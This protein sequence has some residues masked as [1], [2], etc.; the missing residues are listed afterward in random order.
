MAA[1]CWSKSLTI[2]DLTLRLAPREV[3][4]PFRDGGLA[5]LKSNGNDPFHADLVRRNGD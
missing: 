1:G 5:D 3:E 4:P 2:A